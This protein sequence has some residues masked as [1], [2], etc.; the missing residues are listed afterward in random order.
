[1]VFF[2]DAEGQGWG[3]HVSFE[4]RVSSFERCTLL[5][6]DAAIRCQSKSRVA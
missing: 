6:G 3:L 4:F 1:L 5:N 2:F